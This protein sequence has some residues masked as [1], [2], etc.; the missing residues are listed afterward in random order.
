MENRL[1]ALLGPDRARSL[2]LERCPLQ[3]KQVLYEAHAPIAHVYFPLAGIISFV[4]TMTDGAVAEVATVGREGIVGTPVFLG[5][6]SASSKAF[7]QVPGEALRMPAESFRAALEENALLRRIV[8]RYTQAL[9]AQISQGTACNRLH[10]VEERL[11]RWLLM[12]HDRVAGD[13]IPL[14]QEFLAEMLAV[15]RPTV[16]VI[17]GMLQRAGMIEYARGRIRIVQREALE[18][19]SCECYVA[20]RREF[21]RLLA[22]H[23]TPGQL[24]DRDVGDALGGAGI[25]H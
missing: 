6:E 16:T 20:V 9:I 23:H 22:D 24:A 2:P 13:E 1:L 15:R 19:A 14:T 12:T 4:V 25:D 18:Q 11:C 3:L 21:D 7:V 17:A 5:A 10:S 8:G